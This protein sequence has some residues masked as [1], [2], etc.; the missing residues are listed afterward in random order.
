MKPNEASPI[1]KHNK[2]K[3]SGNKAFQKKLA[4]AED[5]LHSL[6]KRELQMFKLLAEGRSASEIAAKLSLS[7]KTIGAHRTNIRKKMGFRNAVQLVRMAIRCN[8]IKP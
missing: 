6:S 5:S 8:V 4:S 7:Q 1:A 3:N 2:P